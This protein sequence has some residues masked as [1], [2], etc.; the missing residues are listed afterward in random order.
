MEDSSPSP[1]PPPPTLRLIF[2]E[3]N[4]I[5]KAQPRHFLLLSFLFLIPLSMTSTMYPIFFKSLLT[6]TAFAAQPS[7][8]ST[9]TLLFVLAYTLFIW[10]FSISAVG[11]ITYSVIKA[12]HGQPLK[13]ESAIKSIPTSFFRIL[14]TNLL[15][16]IIIFL[17]IFVFMLVF[18]S[19]IMGATLLGYRID[20]SSPYFYLLSFAIGM[21]LFPVLIFL[22]VNWSLSSVVVVAETTWGWASLKRSWC[23]IKGRRWLVFSLSLC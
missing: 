23:L 4:R 13:L 22:Q 12:F 9:N 19:F 15:S 5:L 21:A 1:P 16:H 20:F 7:A 14:A 8:I 2:S 6:V 3:T 10:V 18:A 11:S 17:I